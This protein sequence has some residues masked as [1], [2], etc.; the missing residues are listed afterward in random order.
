VAGAVVRHAGSGV[1]G[2]RSDFTMFHGHR[3]RIWTFVKNTPGGWFWLLLPY[4]LGFDLLYLGSA[5]RRGVFAPVWRSYVAA[6]RGLG[7]MW[8]ERRRLA[9]TRRVP[10][11]ETLRVFALAPGAPFRRALRP[12]G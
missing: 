3:N 10:Y 12:R 8:R 1:S 9:R 6:V 5:V 2:R 4:H 7:P 11:R